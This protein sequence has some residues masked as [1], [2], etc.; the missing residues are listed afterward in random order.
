MVRDF[1][2]LM[3][4]TERARQAI[5]R[6]EAAK[7][8]VRIAHYRMN[9][10]EIGVKYNSS[11]SDGKLAKIAAFAK[12]AA[13]Q[14]NIATAT[15]ERDSMVQSAAA[16]LVQIRRELVGL[17]VKATADLGALT[18]ELVAEVEASK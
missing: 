13:S 8:H 12:K 6:L 16:E 14:E 9:S 7:D 17:C 15:R 18:R 1:E 4:A 3:Q 11:D 10:I 5:R 2:R